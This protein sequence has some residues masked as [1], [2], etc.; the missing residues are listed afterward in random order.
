[1]VF[2][3]GGSGLSGCEDGLRVLASSVQVYKLS[4]DQSQ[5]YT[6]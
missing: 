4:H 6:P 2:R 1:M 5:V 3:K